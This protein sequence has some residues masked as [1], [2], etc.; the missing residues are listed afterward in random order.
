LERI[1]APCNLESAST[2]LSLVA[3]EP[4]SIYAC[5]WQS[6]FGMVD[7]STDRSSSVLPCSVLPYK[8]RCGS[9][10]TS[11]IPSFLPSFYALN[12][13]N[14]VRRRNFR[15]CRHCTQTTRSLATRTKEE[16]VRYISYLCIRSPVDVETLVAGQTHLYTM[17]GTLDVLSTH[18]AMSALYWP[19]GYYA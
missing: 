13:L 16:T 11:S 14:V 1:Y 3:N 12:V 8:G 9:A 18:F 2:T 4:H 17:E 10:L 15:R 5:K 6:K 19:T 7:R